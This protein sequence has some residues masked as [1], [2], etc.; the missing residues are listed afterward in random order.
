MYDDASTAPPVRNAI[1]D[2]VYAA[3]RGRIIDLD[4][5]PGDRLQ[6]ERLSREIDV[7]PTPVREA[8]NRLTAEGL[9]VQEPYRGFRVSALL[10]A[11]ELAELLTAR[12]VIESAAASAAAAHR[13]REALTNLRSLVD[14]M[15]T[16]AGEPVLDVKRFNAADAS[17][18]RAVVSAAGNRFLLTAFASLHAHVQISRQYKGRSVAQARRSND[19]H[20]QLL[21]ALDAQ[22]Q[23]LAEEIARAHIDAVRRGLQDPPEETS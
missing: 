16:L 3:L 4:L 20:R 13:S 14:E 19:E 10:D 21:D 8:L 12:T 15:A 18:H 7:S 2:R 22:D 5:A 9:V 23:S 1:T 11:A 17:F 6:I